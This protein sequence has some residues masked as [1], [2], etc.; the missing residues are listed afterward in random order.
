MTAAL[1]ALS[2]AIWV[3]LIAFRGGF[4]RTVERD[5]ALVADGRSAPLL[6]CQKAWPIPQMGD[7]AQ[8]EPT[9]RIRM[10]MQ[11]RHRTPPHSRFLYR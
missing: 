2:L 9:A 7:A 4:W 6:N 3:Y 11:V 5:D 1:A 10:Q 8:A